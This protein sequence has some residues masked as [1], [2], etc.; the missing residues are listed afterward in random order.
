[1]IMAWRLLP[2]F[3]EAFHDKLW[4][5]QYMRYNVSDVARRAA[6]MTLKMAASRRSVGVERIRQTSTQMT[7]LWNKLKHETPFGMHM[8]LKQERIQKDRRLIDEWKRKTK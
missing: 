8:E 3:Y 6:G 2:F 5:A 4:S 1:M 7:I